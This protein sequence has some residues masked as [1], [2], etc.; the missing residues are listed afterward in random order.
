MSRVMAG[1]AEVGKLAVSLS[2]VG[3]FVWLCVCVGERFGERA[4]FVLIGG[5]FVVGVFLAGYFGSDEKE[6][7]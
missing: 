3:G 4:S 6:K 1:L 2:V 7:P 5:V